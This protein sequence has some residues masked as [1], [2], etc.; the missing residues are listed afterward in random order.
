MVWV[1][2]VLLSPLNRSKTMTFKYAKWK[3]NQASL[4]ASEQPFD[5][6]AP[7]PENESFVPLN[8]LNMDMVERRKTMT[9]KYAKWKP[10][11]AS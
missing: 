3:P 9:F 1:L 5:P 2:H 8:K 7:I 4:T 6:C 10:N 11:Q